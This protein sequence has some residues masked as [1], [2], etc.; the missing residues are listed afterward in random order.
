M[1]SRPHLGGPAEAIL[2]LRE[3]HQGGQDRTLC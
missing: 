3:A 2:T 1:L